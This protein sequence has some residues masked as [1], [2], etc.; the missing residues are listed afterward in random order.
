MAVIAG[1]GKS[2]TLPLMNADTTD[3]KDHS[4]LRV[5]V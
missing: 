1:I 5:I 4:D 2:K 3:S